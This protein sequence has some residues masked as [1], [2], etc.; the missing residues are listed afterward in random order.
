MEKEE[1][2]KKLN[3][4]LLERELLI[5]E[6]EQQCREKVDQLFKMLNEKSDD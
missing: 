5:K 1:F 2:E 4:I 3:L 6:I